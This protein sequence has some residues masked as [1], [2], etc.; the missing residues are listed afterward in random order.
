MIEITHMYADKHEW[1]HD[2]SQEKCFICETGR[3]RSYFRLSKNGLEAVRCSNC[4]VVIVINSPINQENASTFY[5]MNAF[6]G[7]RELQNTDFYRGYYKNCFVGYDRDDLTILQFQ[8]ILS[9]IKILCNRNNSAK[10]LDVGCAT[11]VFLDMARHDGWEVKGIEISEELAKYARE[12]F[13]LEIRSDL[14]KTPFPQRSF[15]VVTMLDV[16]EHLPRP[17][18]NTII[19]EISRII[20]PGGV[21][22]IRTPSEDALL[23][24]VG[25]LVYFVSGKTIE[26]PMHLFYSY[27]HILNF[28]PGAL[29]S[30]LKRHQ[31]DLVL[32]KRE[33][34]NPQR[35]NLNKAI[36]VMLQCSY[37]FSKLLK[38]EHKIIHFYRL[39]RALSP[40]T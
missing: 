15:D 16:I 9:E 7:Q 5:S 40:P 19:S 21:M 11:G 38:R 13:H 28:T 23:R 27:E 24:T 17:I 18:V 26:S 39:S 10:L 35:L 3:L 2:I 36:K 14:I 33:E 1:I 37:S 30:I 29:E 4:A 34:E 32:R 6:K 20:K 31:F 22:V 25:K 12:N 8:Q